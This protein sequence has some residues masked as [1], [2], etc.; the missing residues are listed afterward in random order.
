MST[1]LNTTKLLVHLLS[2]YF[3]LSIFGNFFYSLKGINAVLLFLILIIFL[4]KI[5]FYGKAYLKIL[6]IVLFIFSFQSI[7]ILKGQFNSLDSDNI[8]FLSRYMVALLAFPV[9]YYLIE[10]IY[11]SKIVNT[12]SKI[13]FIKFFIMT[14]IILDLNFITL[15]RTEIINFLYTYTNIKPYTPMEGYTRVFDSFAPFFPLILFYLNDKNKINK[16]LI[17]LSLIVYLFYVGSVGIWVSY[18][19]VITLLYFKYVIPILVISFVILFSVYHNV[20][21]DFL[22]TKAVSVSIKLAQKQYVLSSITLFGEG[23]GYEFIIGDTRGFIIENLFLYYMKTYG[24]LG[25]LVYMIIFVVYPM[26]VLAINKSNQYVLFIGLTYL[27]ILTSSFS[28]PYLM[29]G[30]SMIILMILLSFEIFKNQQKRRA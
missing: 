27:S 7:Y 9:I 19:I 10:N 16:F 30:V 12:M 17:H 1:Q 5:H 25:F 14:L 3:F 22:T 18:L 13:V 4:F 24:I 15:Y 29:S 26:Y 11:L 8:L 23:I 2:T 6:L 20:I 21:F 28:N